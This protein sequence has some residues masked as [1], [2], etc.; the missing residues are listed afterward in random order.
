MQL[1]IAEMT[2]EET[3]QAFAKAIETV[4]L[5]NFKAT[6]LFVRNADVSKLARAA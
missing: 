2:L 3:K 5:E 4:G 1:G 6:T